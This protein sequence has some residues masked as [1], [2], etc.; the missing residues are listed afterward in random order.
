MLDWVQN[1][2]SAG[3]GPGPPCAQRTPGLPFYDVLASM[4]IVLF[5]SSQLLFPDLPRPHL[6]LK[7]VSYCVTFEDS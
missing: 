4:D 2:G 6:S 3:A 7:C 1:S 5:I